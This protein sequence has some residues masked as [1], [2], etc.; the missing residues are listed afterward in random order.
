MKAKILV[1]GDCFLDEYITGSCTRISQEAPVPI[2]EVDYGRD[3]QCALGGAG[4]T[5]ANIASLGGCASLISLVNPYDIAGLDVIALARSQALDL[6]I[7][8]DGRMT[9]RKIRLLAQGQ[10]LLR[11]D[12]EEKRPLQEAYQTSILGLFERR[13]PKASMVVLSDYAKGFFSP[14]LLQLII[15]LA[16]KHGKPVI[17]DP[18]PGNEAGYTNASYV[19]PNLK[20]LMDM[21]GN[22]HSDYKKAAVKFSLDHHCGV[23]LTR[24]EKG[25]TLVRGGEW[26]GDWASVAREVFDVSGAGDTVVAAFSL[27]LAQGKTEEEAIVFANKA[28]GVVVGKHG[29]ATVTLEE[30]K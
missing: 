29:T 19:T 17:I 13:L 16:A 8:N 5:A 1:L 4:N 18:K 27:A 25:I 26:I 7:I 21:T 24:G 6:G 11:L 30:I 14:T 28:A 3:R 15:K 10:Q 22:V 20:E 2:L 9:T 23:L 12:Y